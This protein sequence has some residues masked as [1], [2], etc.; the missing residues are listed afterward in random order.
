M[1]YGRGNDEGLEMFARDAV[2]AMGGWRNARR[3]LRATDQTTKTL[4]EAKGVLL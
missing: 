3:I 2:D 4:I 1:F